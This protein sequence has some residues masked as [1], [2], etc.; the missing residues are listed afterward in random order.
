MLS[1]STPG[2]LLDDA[3]HNNSSMQFV[4]DSETK[5]S[6]TRRA[7]LNNHLLVCFSYWVLVSTQRISM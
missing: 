3:N 2:M 4:P 7:L 1:N 6:S 5:E